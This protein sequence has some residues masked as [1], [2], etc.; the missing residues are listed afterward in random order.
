MARLTRRDGAFDLD[1]LLLSG[2]V[3]GEGDGGNDGAEELH[4][5]K[6]V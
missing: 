6:G 2:S 1:G 3:G 4:G 5:V